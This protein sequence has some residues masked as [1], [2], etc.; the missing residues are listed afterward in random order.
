[1]SVIRD[2]NSEPTF[3]MD[4]LARW[5]HIGLTYKINLTSI[6]PKIPRVAVLKDIDIPKTM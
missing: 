6:H 2:E 5:G 4:Q 1:M 3:D